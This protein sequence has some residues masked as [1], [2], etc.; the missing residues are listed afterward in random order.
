MGFARA[1]LTQEDDIA[2]LV[3]I[4]PGCQLMQQTSIK[5]GGRLPI[6]VLQRLQER[7]LSF[8]QPPFQAILG[9][10]LKFDLR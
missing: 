9:P 7:K 10:P 2:M 8:P 6:K 1:A 5:T 4:F 3:D